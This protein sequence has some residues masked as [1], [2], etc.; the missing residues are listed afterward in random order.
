MYTGFCW[1]NLKEEITGK[2][3]AYTYIV[4][5]ETD[6][7]QTG[8]VNVDRINVAQDMNKWRTVVKTAVNI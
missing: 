5:F 7:R 1:G 2:S 6:L 4:N 3:Q 8:R